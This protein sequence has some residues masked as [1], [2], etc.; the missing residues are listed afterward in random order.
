MTTYQKLIR[1]PI[2]RESRVTLYRRIPLR[3]RLLS[4]R[5]PYLRSGS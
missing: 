2:G 1:D 5:K 4:Y 3:F